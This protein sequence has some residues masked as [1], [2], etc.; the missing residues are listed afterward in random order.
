M[1]PAEAGAAAA[2][3]VTIP[4]KRKHCSTPTAAEFRRHVRLCSYDEGCCIIKR[5][6]SHCHHASDTSPDMSESSKITYLTESGEPA[7][8]HDRRMDIID[9]Y[10]SLSDGAVDDPGLLC[11]IENSQSTPPSQSVSSSQS[12]DQY[13][14][15]CHES[16]AIIGSH[17]EARILEA[18]GSGQIYQVVND[19]CRRRRLLERQSDPPRFTPSLELIINDDN[20]HYCQGRSLEDCETSESGSIAVSTTELWDIESCFN[21]DAIKTS[22]T[23]N[24]PL[25]RRESMTQ[26]SEYSRNPRPSRCDEKCDYSS[27]PQGRNRGLRTTYGTCSGGS[28]HDSPSEDTCLAAPQAKNLIAFWYRRLGLEESDVPRLTMDIWNRVLNS[29]TTT[30]QRR[31]NDSDNGPPSLAATPLQE[32]PLSGKHGTVN[33][34][35]ACLWT[36]YKLLYKRTPVLRAADFKAMLDE[37]ALTVSVGKTELYIMKLLEW[38][39]LQGFL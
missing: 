10:R 25:G 35:A 27:C 8:G 14:R 11:W 26:A 31:N 1:E 5:S 39:P 16:Q 13:I 2:D 19:P 6:S 12:G 18:D 4:G 9:S 21:S 28:S 24:S 33:V 7:P 34:L 36:S 30:W 17:F 15:S 3:G 38:R 37:P 22:T 20:T 32:H 23:P 29:H